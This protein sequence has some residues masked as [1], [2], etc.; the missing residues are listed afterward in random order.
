MKN[1]NEKPENKE[2]EKKKEGKEEKAENEEDD[3]VGMTI[4]E[5]EWLGDTGASSHITYNQNDL[6]Q[7]NNCEHKVRVGGGNEFIICSKGK[8]TLPG[9]GHVASLRDALYITNF[10]KKL[11][12]IGR[13]LKEGGV[14]RGD[15]DTLTVCNKNMKLRFKSRDHLQ[16]FFYALGNLLFNA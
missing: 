4:V 14:L 1:C 13:I 10:G 11:I 8:M 12:S 15:K 16:L 9:C 7:V 3:F 5:E 2:K 6:E